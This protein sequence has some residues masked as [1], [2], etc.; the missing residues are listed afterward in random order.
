M[1][2]SRYLVVASAALLMAGITLAAPSARQ[3]TS[4]STS[5]STMKMSLHHE[6][7]VVESITSS[8]LMLSHIRK[9]KT[10]TTTFKIDPSTKQIGTID[11]GA[12]VVVYYKNENGEHVA[13]EVKARKTKA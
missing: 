3:A 11:K 1:K 5:T 6:S 10:E 12:N 9:G 2:F 8:D 7:G 13:T 4:A